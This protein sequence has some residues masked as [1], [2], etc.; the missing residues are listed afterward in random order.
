[1]IEAR[2]ISRD[3][4]GNGLGSTDI[5]LDKGGFI[6]ISGAS[7]CGKS[8]LLNILTGMLRPDSGTVLI[9][10]EDIN[11]LSSAK[12]TALR[13]GK[14]GYIMQGS[15]LLGEL[16]VL[17]N[18]ILPARIAGKKNDNAKAEKLCEKLG[19]D[20]V[21]NSYPSDISGGEYRRTMLARILFADTP[22]LVADEPTSNLDEE[23]AAIVRNM[24]KE[25]HDKGVSIIAA[26]HDSELLSLAD[27][28][29]QLHPLH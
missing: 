27:S 19:I 10:G 15:V 28:V 6:G 2:N 5:S 21:M 24:I 3:F 4:G 18:I 1:M 8:T 17:E 12:R 11:K 26:T 25:V 16:T 13:A 20:N 23:S 14:I 29:I 9:D 22:I 7:G